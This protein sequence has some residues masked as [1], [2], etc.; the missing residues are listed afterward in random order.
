VKPK[1]PGVKKFLHESKKQQKTL[2]IVF[3]LELK[4]L[5]ASGKG[6]SLVSWPDPVNVR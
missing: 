5:V 4:G 6:F 1:K 2:A 3:Q